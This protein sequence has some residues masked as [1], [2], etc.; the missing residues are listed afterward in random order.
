MKQSS[1]PLCVRAPENER[2]LETQEVKYGGL[3]RDMKSRFCFALG[4]CWLALLGSAPLRADENWRPAHPRLITEWGEQVRPDN[5]W[6]EYPRPQFVRESWKNLNGLW[7]FAVRAKTQRAPTEFDGTILVPFAIESALSGVGKSFTPDDRLW[8]RRRFELPAEWK[9]QR[10]LL[11]LG[12]VD[13]EAT[14]WINGALVGSHRGGSDPFT[15]DISDFLK[16]GP[17]ELLLSVTDPTDRGEQPRGKQ[18][19]S[20]KGIWYTPVSGIWQTVWLEPVP[21][22]LHLAEL[23]LTPEVRNRRLVVEALVNEPVEDDRSAVRLTARASG[24]VVAT[25][26]VRVNRRGWLDLPEPKLWSAEHPFLYDLTAELVQVQ[27][28]RQPGGK[29]RPRLPAFGQ[30]ERLAYAQAQVTGDPSDTVKSY[31]AMR[32]LTLESSGPR[33]QPMLCLNGT[34]VFQ[35]GP[36]DQGWWPDGLLTPPSDAAMVWELEWLK[37]AGFNMLRKH[38]K[39]EPDRY[40]YHC[41]RLGL[42]IWQDMPSGFRRALRNDRGDDGEPLR[43]STS[44]EQH[45]LELRRMIARLYNHPSIV[46]WVLHNEGWGQYETA[47]LAPWLKAIDPSRW[48]NPTSGWLDQNLG[49]VYDIHTYQPLPLAPMNKPDRAI[50]IGE[51]G[52]VGWPVAG[53]LWDAG[54][55]N[56]GYQTY[57][58]RDAYV[59][60]VMKK[61]EAL[62]P[63]RR[64]LG[65]SAAVYTQTTDVEGEVN[66]LLTYDRRVAKIAPA[67]LKGVN[68]RLIGRNL[69]SAATK[70]S[71]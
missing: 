41:D 43:L 17:T 10:I 21:R 45:E 61:I 15:F 5:A 64:D 27:N 71:P 24:A 1:G 58:D 28:P 63:M 25:T 46:M 14:L 70:P 2:W 66:G 48:I 35:H 32:E 22:S 54:K 19:L 33:Q 51:Y 18:E 30:A 53:H 3:R 26:T 62:V 29:D 67:K 37:Q 60:A 9:Q 50:V 36:L 55:K 39:V 34:P 44:R 68:D 42:L 20:P 31:F 16:A 38:I 12:A 69:P 59:D 65:L 56:W 8:Y 49:D 23:R 47:E 52:G 57:G 11:H 4:A 7:D 13:Y 6:A 40:Y